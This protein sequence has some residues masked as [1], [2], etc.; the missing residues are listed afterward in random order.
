MYRQTPLMFQYTFG[1]INETGALELEA[2]EI[3]D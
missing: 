2:I 3:F 1:I